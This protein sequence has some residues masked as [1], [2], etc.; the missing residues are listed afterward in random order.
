[1]IKNILKIWGWTFFNPIKTNRFIQSTNSTRLVRR[2][3]VLLGAL[4]G[5]V[6]AFIYRGGKFPGL[7]M[8]LLLS[9]FGILFAA[10]A[11]VGLK[12]SHTDAFGISL[13]VMLLFFLLI[14]SFQRKVNP[15][16]TNWKATLIIFA[17]I[18]LVFFLAWRLSRRGMN[19]SFL[20]WP[21]GLCGFAIF[22]VQKTEPWVFNVI[23][24]IG[25]PLPAISSSALLLLALIIF[26]TYYAEVFIQSYK[27]ISKTE[28]YYAYTLSS[29]K[30][31]MALT[32]F[33]FSLACWGASLLFPELI[34]LRFTATALLVGGILELEIIQYM[35]L[36][37][38]LKYKNSRLI[39]QSLT[40]ITDK[41]RNLLFLIPTV[42]FEPVGIKK[43]LT[44]LKEIKGEREAAFFAA[45]LL[46]ETGYFR[47]ARKWISQLTVYDPSLYFLIAERLNQAVPTDLQDESMKSSYDLQKEEPLT[48]S[49]LY[50]EEFSHASLDE[51]LYSHYYVPPRGKEG[52]PLAM[53]PIWF[54]V[55]K[56]PFETM[57]LSQIIYRSL[58]SVREPFRRTKLTLPDPKTAKSAYTNLLE[59]ALGWANSSPGAS[60][61][62]VILSLKRLVEQTSNIQGIYVQLK[63][64][65]DK[66]DIDSQEHSTLSVFSACQKIIQWGSMAP[67]PNLPDVMTAISA[68]NAWLLI[69]DDRQSNSSLKTI[70]KTLDLVFGH[71]EFSHVAII[72]VTDFK[73]NCRILS[74][75]QT[76]RL[77]EP[78][79]HKP[80]EK[81]QSK[82]NFSIPDK[83]VALFCRI[84][85]YLGS[86]SIKVSGLITVAVGL[87]I[88]IFTITNYESMALLTSKEQ[89]IP[90]DSLDMVKPLKTIGVSGIS[91]LFIIPFVVGYIWGLAYGSEE[92]RRSSVD[93]MIV[94][95]LAVVTFFLILLPKS[96][97]PGI[98]KTILVIIT[99]LPFSL[100]LAL[101]LL[102]F[103]SMWGNVIWLILSLRITRNLDKQDL[104]KFCDSYSVA[105]H[106][107]H[108]AVPVALPCK[109]GHKETFPLL[110][111]FKTGR[112]IPLVLDTFPVL[113]EHFRELIFQG[114]KK[115]KD[116]WLHSSYSSSSLLL[117]SLIGSR[118]PASRRCLRMAGN[119]CVDA[120]NDRDEFTEYREPS[121]TFTM[122]ALEYAARQLCYL[123]GLE[124]LIVVR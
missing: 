86:P 8:V 84:F 71:K 24:K 72:V 67:I 9:G 109:A 61:I 75:I 105:L 46:L 77:A 103:I 80:P 59:W 101:T 1:M 90:L 52:A 87:L 18:A 43:Y 81:N 49:T 64:T 4:T 27:H 85:S 100:L 40:E 32:Y 99:A 2:A 107:S 25:G 7:S 30:R 36:C 123:T 91:V 120:W 34:K 28:N 114:L 112:I 95:L 82:K 29:F 12:D 98:L 44:L 79:Y 106:I 122:N 108:Q 3:L 60:L 14:S 58:A 23:G 13:L 110:I 65:Q 47:E 50:A 20:F 88:L 121:T 118:S 117:W 51:Q 11:S 97:S 96:M 35:F 39:A 113:I 10:V 5:F 78:D 89:V 6:I 94:P 68:G 92:V 41:N 31:N 57:T 124:E 26:K 33:I 54:P 70:N 111:C 22:S 53:L 42:P 48:V 38:W 15:S 55:A 45:Q 37:C 83:K 115:E 73:K 74:D 56:P 16:K 69:E 116:D 66:T 76:F 102:A 19:R 21:I 17:V 93:T 63:Q 104:V 119:D 62:P